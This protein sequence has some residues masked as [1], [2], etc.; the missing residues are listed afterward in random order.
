MVPSACGLFE[1]SQTLHWTRRRSKTLRATFLLHQLTAVL[2]MKAERLEDLEPTT[3]GEPADKRA[4]HTEMPVP[5]P[6]AAGVP[7]IDLAP[8]L[9]AAAASGLE[10]L[11]DAAAAVAR[12]WRAAFATYGFAH[13]VGHG[14]PDDVIEASYSTARRFFTL[15]PEEKRRCDLGRGYGPGG[16]TAQG[17]ERV[18]ATASRPD[19]SA[20]LGAAHARPPDRV[21]SASEANRRHS[22]PC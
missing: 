2:D 13:I 22:R 16:Y 5:A 19:G 8:F 21:E 15:S 12:Q 20:L 17:G 11:P 10:P 14:V 4:R 3:G 7:V 9:A 1:W 6:V 18:S